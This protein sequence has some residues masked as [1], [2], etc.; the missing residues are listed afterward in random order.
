MLPREPLFVLRL[1]HDLQDVILAVR[2]VRS[3]VLYALGPR[4][5]ATV[6][7]C[8]ASPDSNVETFEELK[9]YLASD[10]KELL[11]HASFHAFAWRPASLSKYFGRLP[12][13]GRV[14]LQSSSE[15]SQKYQEAVAAALAKEVGASF[16]VLDSDLLTA[17][18]KQAMGS[19]TDLGS[20][21][22]E[23]IDP[24]GGAILPF[25]LSFWLSGGRIAFVYEVIRRACLTVK[26]PLLVFIKDADT[27]VCGN[28]DRYD[29]FVDS[30]GSCHAAGEPTDDL[31]GPVRHH[32]VPFML[33]GGTALGDSGS[34]LTQGS[35][36]QGD[37]DADS[38]MG[39]TPSGPDDALPGLIPSAADLG[40][41]ITD[42]RPSARKLLPRLFM[43]RVRLAAPS[44][45]PQAVAH[46][47]QL[48]ADAQDLMAERNHR[49]AS[50][51]ATRRGVHPT[52]LLRGLQAEATEPQGYWGRVMAWAN[53]MEAAF[54]TPEGH[55][56]LEKIAKETAKD[57]DAQARH[58]QRCC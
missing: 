45:G 15:N 28:W 44:E 21:P 46:R 35:S 31:V 43:T 32:S 30:F 29:A 33:V 52:R 34:H 5:E 41:S 11:L 22:S 18:F 3:F 50:A 55:T 42:D 23:N 7:K 12:P 58:K 56:A 47:Q 57:Q 16:L 13:V 49:H 4:C 20:E 8:L 54:K 24:G 48:Q 2:P 51:F 1:F 6:L 10:A 9:Y 14:L 53:C 26:G 17:I 40:L 27:A 36:S 39:G 25:L 37:Q 38:K 19:S